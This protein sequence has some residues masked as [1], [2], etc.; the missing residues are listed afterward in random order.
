[1]T[2]LASSGI[3][4][5][6]YAG[7]GGLSPQPYNGYTPYIP[8]PPQIAPD[9]GI[10]DNSTPPSQP[11]NT[12]SLLDAISNALSGGGGG[13]RSFKGAAGSSQAQVNLGLQQTQQLLNT[14][15]QNLGFNVNLQNTALNQRAGYVSGNF[16]DQ[17]R[18]MKDQYATSLYGLNAG[19]AASGAYGAIGNN[20]SRYALAENEVVGERELGRQGYYGLEQ[21][22]DAKAKMYSAALLNNLKLDQGL[23]MNALQRSEAGI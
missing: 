21:I 7:L 14:E 2:T 4:S 22:N 20:R 19:A 10:P 15:K 5:Y 23:A 13:S 17:L 11:D 16:Y 6:D 3:P 12:Q 8:T 9:T 1:M 18:S